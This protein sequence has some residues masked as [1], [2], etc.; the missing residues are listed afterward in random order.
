MV[1]V[2]YPKKYIYLRIR[3]NWKQGILKLKEQFRLWCQQTG[4]QMHR[5]NFEGVIFLQPS[6]QQLCLGKLLWMCLILASLSKNIL[7][8]FEV[9]IRFIQINKT[10]FHFRLIALGRSNFFFFQFEAYNKAQPK[11]P[12]K[13]WSYKAWLPSL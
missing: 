5:M 13:P 10:V 12:K 9:I 11:E 3:L 7:L 4:M 6:Y 1:A 2:N 8:Y